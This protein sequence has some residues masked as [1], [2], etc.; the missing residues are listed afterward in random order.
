MISNQILD[1]YE[2][3]NLN[4]IESDKKSYL[5]INI[6]GQGQYPMIKLEE[7][8]CR[9]NA[10]GN[11]QVRNVQ[12]DVEEKRIA[13]FFKQYNQ[14]DDFYQLKLQSTM[15]LPILNKQQSSFPI[16]PNQ[17]Q[18]SFTGIMRRQ[19]TL[20]AKQKPWDQLIYQSSIKKNNA[21]GMIDVD[22]Y[23]QFSSQYDQVYA[24]ACYLPPKKLNIIFKQHD[25]NEQID[26]MNIFIQK[27]QKD[28]PLSFKF[29]KKIVAKR[30]FKKEKSV[31]R[32]FQE[33]T[34]D[35]FKKCFDYDMK[36]SKLKR[37]IRDSQDW[38]VIGG[39]LMMSTIDRLFIAVNVE[40]IDLEDNQDRSLCRYEFFE[41]IVRMAYAKYVDKGP[42]RTIDEGLQKL[43]NEH[44]MENPFEKIDGDSWRHE[45]LW[46]LEVDDLF[47][48]NLKE[49]N[50]VNFQLKSIN[51]QLYKFIMGRSKYVEYDV[52]IDILHESELQMNSEDIT[53]AFAYS[54]QTFIQEME[55]IKRYKNIP[56][57][58][59]LEFI[60]RLAQIK[61]FDV[62][63]P[64][65]NKIEMILDILLK[66]V[67][68]KVQQ[69]QI[70]DDVDSQTD[71]EDDL[72]EIVEK[73]NLLKH[74]QKIKSSYDSSGD[75][76][77]FESEVESFQQ[78]EKLN[79]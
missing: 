26:Y 5:T 57:H 60:G 18:N 12:K 19:T 11:R 64:L 45:E 36:F 8:L 42:L 20:K 51:L 68:E 2:S 16:S 35:L 10:N 76:E 7:F 13:D 1:Q 6:Q 49:I 3:I 30:Q 71:Y 44:I 32:E 59:F 38:N 27:R 39:N 46:C 31:F 61:Y 24:F 74:Q 43:I 23:I 15:N 79:L 67:N 29:I 17:S 55:D 40:I 73:N 53:V 70:S 52:L 33:D 58:E 56:F 4:Q 14:R 66:L 50:K 48:A 37:F 54:K 65:E 72:I 63:V 78:S 75:D 41:I 25:I 21:Q 69:P 47:K 34:D 22:R 62:Q 77:N 9:L 28:V